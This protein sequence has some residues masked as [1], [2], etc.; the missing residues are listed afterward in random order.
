[1]DKEASDLLRLALMGLLSGG[2]TYG[3]LRLMNDI[4]EAA[5]GP[6]KPKNEL[7]LTL[8]ASRIPKTASAEHSPMDYL[9]PLLAYGGGAGAGFMGSS[10]LYD[11]YR[12][13]QLENKEKDIEGQYLQTLQQAHQKVASTDT[14]NVDN[15]LNGLLS[16][17]GEELQKEGFLWENNI[18]PENPLD[19]ISNQGKHLIHGAANTEL[20]SAAIAAWLT[21]TLGAGGA[22]YAIARKMDEQKEKNQAR[23]NLP[24]EIKLNVV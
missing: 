3:A 1:M 21:A 9:L 13:K 20:G 6:K 18:S 16:K 24:N 17:V 22:T 8:P 10:K 4:P 12:R 15:F 19:T 14:P 23:T 2:G 11:M 7:E 5:K